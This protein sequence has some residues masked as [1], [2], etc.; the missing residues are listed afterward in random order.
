MQKLMRRLN[1]QFGEPEWFEEYTDD[2][3]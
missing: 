3:G 1:E 2:I